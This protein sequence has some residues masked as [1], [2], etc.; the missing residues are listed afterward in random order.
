MESPI[1]IYGESAGTATS[2]SPPV[3]QGVL[4]YWPDIEHLT[5]GISETDL[6]AQDISV[7]APDA[8]IIVTIEDRGESQWLRVSDSAS[9]VTDVD[10]GIITPTNYDV[11]LRPY[12]L[13]RQLGF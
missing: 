10:A 8:L 9:P 11:T 12:V 13:H 5:G 4:Y 3:R 2:P 6:D 1:L 7:L